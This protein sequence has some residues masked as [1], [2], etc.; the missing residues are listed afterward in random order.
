MITKITV[1]MTTFNGNKFLK[2]CMD[3]VL[4]QSFEDFEFLIVDDCSAD[5]SKDL[6]KS[7]KDGRI[8]LIENKENLGQVKSLNIGL[9]YARGEY[10]ARMDQDDIMIKNRLKRQLDFLDRRKDISVVGTWGELI[11]ENGRVF[12]KYICPVRNAEMIGN[13]LCGWNSLM[14]MSVIFKKDAVINAGKYNELFPFAEDYD[15]WTRLLL[16]GH[17]LANIPEFLIKCRFHKETS[18][19]NFRGIQIK[20]SS[21]STS[22]FIK[23]INGTYCNSDLDRLLNFLISAGSMNREYWLDEANIAYLRDTIG[24]LEI[25]L[26]N[27][28]KYFKFKKSEIYFMEK[29]F[30]NK[31]LNFAYLS[32]GGQMRGLPLY[33]LCLRNYRYLFLRPKLYLYPIKHALLRPL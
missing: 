29:V 22:N 21:A 28:I 3:S 17:K 2:E 4:N 14:H 11:D 7:Y 23:A 33:L 5:G 18:S 24:L 19:K 8:R 9:E 31:M 20:N 15:L 16:K 1:L 25:L 26:K 10:V 30:F 6:I 13:I 32:C 27:T 12:E